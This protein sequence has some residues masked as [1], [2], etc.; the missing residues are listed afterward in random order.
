MQKTIEINTAQ[1]VIIEYDL[2]PL[3]D[4][5]LAWFIDFVMVIFL[6]IFVRSILVYMLDDLSIEMGW[7][8]FLGLLF[9][10]LY[11]GYLSAMEMWN[12]GQTLGKTALGIKVVRLDGKDPEWSDVLLRAFMHLVDS[13]FCFGIIG[14]LL[15][16][17]TPRQQRLGDM[18]AQTGVIKLFSNNYYYRLD[19]ILSLSSTANYKPVFQ[20]VR[21]LTEK[22]MLFIK[23]VLDQYRLHP[24]DAHWQAVHE[25]A[26]HLIQL[27]KI[28]EIV[29]DK[30]EFLKTLLRDYIVLTR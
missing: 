7:Q 23:S 5:M 19:S 6:F 9:F 15:I 10:I 2:A 30:Q 17:T 16:K 4:R 18:A 22:D 13:M 20:Q 12:F 1:N 3:R 11:F 14:I 28:E 25:L 29:K 8:I 21:Q 24:N 27:L 26:E